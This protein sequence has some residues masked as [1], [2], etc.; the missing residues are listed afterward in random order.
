MGWMEWRP[1]DAAEAQAAMNAFAGERPEL[2]SGARVVDSRAM[3]LAF[4]RSHR[5]VD[6]E[7]LLGDEAFHLFLLDGDDGIIRVL[8]G[9]SQPIH[10]TN[11]DEDLD[12][13]LDTVEEYLRFF[14]LFLRADEGRAFVLLESGDAI[15]PK[16]PGVGEAAAGRIADLLIPLRR[17]DGPVEGPWTYDCAMVSFNELFRVVIRVERSGDV[18]MLDDEPIDVS[19]EDLDAIA[20]P[21]YPD[22]QPAL[23]AR[24]EPAHRSD[25]DGATGGIDHDD[26]DL[27]DDRSRKDRPLNDR[28]VSEEIVAVLLEDALEA[29]AASS[30]DP[31]GS[32]LYAAFNLESM[33]NDPF[34]SFRRMLQGA[35]VVVVLESDIPFVEDVVA[36][37]LDGDRQLVSGGAIARATEV[38]GEELRCTV[39]YQDTSVRLHLISFHA[40]SDLWAAERTANELALAEASVLIGCHRLADVPEPLRRIKNFVLR[41]PDI[42]RARFVRIFERVFQTELPDGWAADDPAWADHLIPEDFH[43]PVRLGLAG[44]EALQFLRQQSTDRLRA[45]SVESALSLDDLKGMSEARQVCEDLLADIRLAVA[46]ELDWSS[47]DHGILLAG[48]PGTGKSTLARAVAKD[49]GIKF[50]NASAADWQSSG[51]LDAH[52]RAIRTSFAE[53]RRYAPA[54][55]FIDEI[56]SVGSRDQVDHNALYQTGVINALLAEIQ[57]FEEDPV[58]VIGATNHP[59]RVDP[60]LRRAGRLDQVVEIPLPTVA[61]LAAILDHHLGR[62]RTKGE[63]A[64]DV[65]PTAIA[66]LCLGQTGADMEFTVRGAWRWARRGRRTTITQ[67]DLLAVVTHRPRHQDSAPL[68]DRAGLHR[69]AVHEAGHAVAN[70]TGS[71]RGEDITYLTIV[72]RLDGSLGFV[73]WV[74]NETGVETRR[75]LIERIEIALAGRAAEEIEFGPADVGVGAGGPS[76]GCDLAAATRIATMLVSQAG[77]GSDGKLRWSEGTDVGQE[78]QVEAILQQAYQAVRARLEDH[79][80]LH[81]RVV[82]IL[83][84]DQELS[85]QQLRRMLAEEA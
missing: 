30:D 3:D 15:R 77:L 37:L 60:A 85:G 74:P 61:G 62:H 81:Q 83:E 19:D 50:V 20:Y 68:Q 7:Y 67:A 35:D 73:A 34:A 57:G 24:I 55:L 38:A 56:D 51:A 17:Q 43:L 66:E 45:L 59:D 75:S 40:F 49:S 18:E 14:L 80:E 44:D 82:A 27:P 13:R 2:Y 29:H 79:E 63:V 71:T 8:D 25:V 54:I 42:D 26:D 46:G 65:D 23:E 47:V 39:R 76:P 32:T 12:L 6:I 21:T 31:S 64:D 84:R 9:T 48:P 11:D 58:I 5:V 78:A 10:D 69:T 53:A 16:V 52:L 72:P 41:F 33:A 70:L 28:R 4:Y 36:G 1:W 22:L